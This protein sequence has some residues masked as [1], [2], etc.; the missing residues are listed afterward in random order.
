MVDWDDDRRRLGLRRPDRGGAARRR[1]GLEATRPRC[2]REYA[3]SIEYSLDSLISWVA[4]VRRRRTWCWSSSATTSRRRSSSART[5]ATTCRSRSSPRTRRCWT[6]SPAGAGRTACSPAPDGPGLADG[7]LPRPVPDRLRGTDRRQ[8]DPLTPRGA[9]LVP[10]VACSGTIMVPCGAMDIT[11]YVS[12][13]RTELANAA[14]LGGAEA[15]ALA[16]RLTA[17]MESAF[18]LALLDALSAAADEITRDLAPG[19]V[20]LRLR[21]REPEL[22]RDP[23]AAREIPLRR[24]GAAAAGRTT[25]PPSPGSTCACPTSSRPGSRRR[26]AATACRSTPGWSGPPRPPCVR[27]RARS[28]RTARRAAASASPAGCADPLRTHIRI[29]PRGGVASPCPFSTPRTDHAPPST[30]SSATSASR[31]ATGRTPSSRSGPATPAP[32]WTS[33]PP[34][35]PGSSTPTAGCWSRRPSSAVLG[36]FGRPGSIDVEI[37]LPAGSQLHADAGVAAVTGAGTLGECRVKTGVG[38]LRWSAPVRPT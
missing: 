7:R 35:R 17:P 23:A 9:K 13:L 2:A 29:P 36:L 32:T 31:P 33:A 14:E 5:P 6:G 22:R 4:E 12:A 38:D 26:R 19:S 27:A 21:G 34:S 25:T 30:W 15:R 11:P 3:K 24:T 28:P 1:D 10:S 8:V 20:Q 37:L 16:E 18:R